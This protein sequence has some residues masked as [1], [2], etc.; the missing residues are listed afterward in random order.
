MYAPLRLSFSLQMLACT[1]LAGSLFS[2]VGA[3]PG[4]RACGL[5]FLTVT[6]FFP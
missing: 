5:V 3:H 2:Y 1:L 6:A 4:V